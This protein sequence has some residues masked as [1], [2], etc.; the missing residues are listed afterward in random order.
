MTV[1]TRAQLNSDADT[2][3]ANNTR[4]EIT[5]TKVRERIKDLA[6]SALLPEDLA[7]PVAFATGSASLPSITHTGDT[8]TGI[9]FGTDIINFSTGGTFAAMFDASR[10]FVIGGATA[11]VTEL[12]GTSVTPNFQILANGVNASMLMARFSNDTTPGRIYFAKSRNTTVGSHTIV[13]AD[14]QLGSFAFGGSDGAAI[15][16]GAFIAAF[17]DGSPS[18]NSMPTRLTF[19]VSPS[20]SEAPVEALRIS[21]TGAITH[22]A[23]AQQIVDA[24]SHLQLRSYAK[25]SL[26]S[27]ATAGQLIYVSDDTG[28]ATPAFS[29]GTNWRRV[30]DRAI[31][32]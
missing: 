20:G 13:Q 24:N 29:D 16:N 12:N 31:V 25:A 22:R 2:N 32:S 19:Q 5:P 6:D 15:A 23:N 17:V 9:Y 21:S 3:L 11:F 26:P 10:R 27:A 30:S 7:S 8:N 4:R 28:G 1:R 18:S 14:D